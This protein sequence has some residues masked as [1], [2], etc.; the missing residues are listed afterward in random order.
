MLATQ[1]M[2]RLAIH[3]HP[4]HRSSHSVPTPSA[5][6]VGF[7]MA[8]LLGFLC[9]ILFSFADPTLRLFYKSIAVYGLTVILL[10]VVSFLDDWKTLSHRLR[11]TIHAICA[12]L[13]VWSGFTIQF[14]GLPVPHWLASIISFFAIIS[15]I[16]AA[17]FIDGLNG[18]LAGSVVLCLVFNCFLLLSASLNIIYVNTLLSAALMGFLIYNFPKAKIFMGDV[19]STFLG[20]TCAFLALLSQNY[21]PVYYA[22]HAWVHKAFI[23]TL[24]PLCFL[25]FDVAFTLLR[26]AL[27][28]KNLAQ[29]HRDHLIHILNDCGYSHPLV[30]GLYFFSAFLMGGLTHLCHQGILSFLQ[31]LLIYS[32]LQGAFVFWVF[33]TKKRKGQGIP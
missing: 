26:R 21:Y 9:L 24:T 6:G 11:L 27:K 2:I 1:V 16:N 28:G 12:F 15:L 19:G 18:L 5:G 20:L 23:F 22:Q 29:A 3:A 33:R 8:F 17:N 32:F 30:S 13:I 10:G 7:I 25:W 14:P 4:V 31:F